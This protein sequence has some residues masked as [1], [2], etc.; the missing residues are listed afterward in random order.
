MIVE[1][2]A[3]GVFAAGDLAEAVVDAEIE[4]AKALDTLQ[5][6]ESRAAEAKSCG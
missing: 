1:R 2:P 4:F 5:A 6:A 3:A